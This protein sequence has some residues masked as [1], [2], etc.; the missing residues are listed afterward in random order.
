VAAQEGGR[1][2]PCQVSYSTEPHNLVLSNGED[3]LNEH[4]PHN[5]AKGGVFSSLISCLVNCTFSVSDQVVRGGIDAT[6][7]G[8]R[9]F[10][11]KQAG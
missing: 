6:S 1:A 9:V 3:R 2:S 10:I 7:A 11:K 8:R 5:M 4:W